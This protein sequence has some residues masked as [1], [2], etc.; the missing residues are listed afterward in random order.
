MRRAE[1]LPDEDL[2]RRVTDGTQEHLR[3]YIARLTPNS[4]RAGN[5]LSDVLASLIKECR[6]PALETIDVFSQPK[7][8][9]TDGV[10]VTPALI[11][12]KPNNRIMLMGDLG[13]QT[14]LRVVLR[15]FWA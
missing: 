11:A 9:L 10:V 1:M 5:N 8:A 2:V 12:I 3:L 15:D 7:R 4:V 14:K 13:D 6:I